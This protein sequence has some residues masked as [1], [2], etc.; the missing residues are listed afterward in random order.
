MSLQDLYTH[1]QPAE[2]EQQIKN[3]R[4]TIQ[5]ALE[6]RAGVTSVEYQGAYTSPTGDYDQ[7][8]VE[9][10]DAT[11]VTIRAFQSLGCTTERIS[12][13]AVLVCCRHAQYDRRWLK[14]DLST[15][16]WCTLTLM[17][18]LALALVLAA[19]YL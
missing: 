7:F 2:I 13:H 9:T 15:P 10:N 8:Y 14:V 18:A 12:S 3:G 16:Q 11:D 17:L 1:Q 5:Q 4:Q 19:L 6:K